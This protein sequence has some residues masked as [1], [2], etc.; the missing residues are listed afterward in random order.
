M[1]IDIKGN[2]YEAS[3]VICAVPLKVLKEKVIAL[4][5]CISKEKLSAIETLDTG[6]CFKLFLKFKKVFWPEDALSFIIEGPMP[7]FW[8]TSK[9]K[10]GTNTHI[11]HVLMSGPDATKLTTAKDQNVETSALNQLK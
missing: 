4:P 6:D 9:P 2:T 7:I 11:L 10:K 1:A 3:S 8:V 5:S